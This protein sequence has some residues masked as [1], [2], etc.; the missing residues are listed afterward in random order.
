VATQAL[1]VRP[2]PA[3]ARTI[4]ASIEDHV[5]VTAATA[6]LALVHVVLQAPTA[7]HT[8]VHARKVHA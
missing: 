4:H 7:R 8:L 5:S 1:S 2:T 3:H 6:I